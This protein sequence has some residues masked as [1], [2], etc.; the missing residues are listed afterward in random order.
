M[1]M[2]ICKMLFFA[3]LSLIVGKFLFDHGMGT[4]SEIRQSSNVDV[5]EVGKDLGLLLLLI[6]CLTG[7]KHAWA[8]RHQG[9]T[10]KTKKARRRTR[11]ISD[12][13]N[14]PQ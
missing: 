13:I 3:A 7:V 12:N 6:F 11:K 8:H 10:S 9:E 4:L 5:P 14:I 2:T 1:I